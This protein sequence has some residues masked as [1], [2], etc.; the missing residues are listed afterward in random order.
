MS[1]SSMEIAGAADVF[2]QQGRPVRGLRWRRLVEPVFEDRGDTGVGQHADFDRSAADR[3]GSRRI[4]AAEQP[5]HAEAATKPLFWMRPARQHRQDQR[6]GLGTDVTRLA[7]EPFS[8]PF[9]IASV[10]TGRS[11]SRFRPRS[12]WNTS[13]GMWSGSVP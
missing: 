12:G 5:Q 9:A 4:E 6:L 7:G 3:L 13:G 10:R 11:W 2:V 8:R 1:F